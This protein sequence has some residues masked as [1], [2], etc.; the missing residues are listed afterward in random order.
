MKHGESSRPC[1]FTSTEARLER[2]FCA[3]KVDILD[4][5]LGRKERV[6]GGEGGVE[7]DEGGGLRKQFFRREK[8]KTLLGSDARR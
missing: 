2:K 1:C 5:W 6:R 7:G 4:G 8:I 3:R